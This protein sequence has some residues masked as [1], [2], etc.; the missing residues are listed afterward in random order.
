M[1]A[2]TYFRQ[3]FDLIKRIQDSQDT[4]ISD[5]AELMAN[6]IESDGWV[7]L[8]GSGHSVLPVLDVFPRYG[9]YIGFR[10]LMD[11]RLMW[12]NVTGPG[13]ASELLWLERQ[14]GY[15]V[16][17]LKSYD[18]RAN[19]TLLV[20]SHGGLNAAAI[21][22]AQYVKDEG[23]SVIAVTSMDNYRK[24]APKHSSGKKLADLAD[25]VIDNCVPL[26][27]TLVDVGQLEKVG[28]GSTLSVIVIS[29]ALVA[30]TAARLRQRGHALETFVS[31]NV[32]GVAPNHNEAVFEAYKA[33]IGRVR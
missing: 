27:D 7:F 30:E 21:E 25:V 29:M 2:E 3:S 18:F 4:V 28:A 17:F 9:S 33:R 11:P 10:P 19:D 12:F 26:E 23:C 22:A 5:A 13:G 20:Y 16:N 31:P 1:S 8:F 15:I 6:S 14:E 32:K 24:A